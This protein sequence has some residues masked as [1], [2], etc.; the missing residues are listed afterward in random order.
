MSNQLPANSDHAPQP[1]LPADLAQHA[2]LWETPE[3]GSPMGSAEQLKRLLGAVLRRKWLILG[4]TAV[5]AGAGVVVGR[6]VE[7]EYQAQTT[8][9]IESPNSSKEGPIQTGLLLS[10]SAW[11]DLLRSFVVLDYVVAREKLFIESANPRDFRSFALQQQFRPGRYRVEVSGDGRSF[12]LSLE[13]AQIQRGQVGEPVGTEVGFDWK[14]GRGILSPGRTLD[15]EVRNPRD[16]A[17][18]LAGT[19]RPVLNKENNFLR[20][21]LTGSDPARTARTLNTLADRYVEVAAE[22]K[23]DKLDQ[24]TAVL[25]EQRRYA[26]ENLR[27][28]E[29]GLESFRVQTITLPSDKGTPMAAGLQVTTDPVLSR[30]F[31]LQVQRE[32]LRSDRESIDRILAEASQSALSMDALLTVSSV[33]EAPALRTVLENRIGKRA[34]LRTTLQRY[35]PEHPEAVKIREDMRELE[36][37]TIPELTGELEAQLLDREAELEARIASA[38]G[39]LRQIPPRAIEEARLQR[40]VSTAENLHKMLKQ[41]FEEARLAAAS[42]IPDIRVLDAATVPSRPVSDPRQV[43]VLLGLLGGL[44]ISVLGTVVIDRLDSHVRYPEEITH[45]MG[46]QILG[47]VP[48]VNLIGGGGDPT[49]VAAEAFREL[50]LSLI[51]A[52]GSSGPVVTTISSPGSGDGKSFVAS[53]LAL[54]FADQGFRTL[55]IDGDIRRGGLHRTLD[56]QRTLG[57]TDF[58][59]GGAA[60]EEVIQATKFPNVHFIGAGTRMVHGPELLGSPAMAQLLVNVRKRF[61]AIIVDS[62]PLGAGVDAYALGTITHNLILVVRTGATDRGF[63]AA[64]LHVLDRLPIRVLGA[65]LNGAPLNDSAYKYYSYIPGYSVAG[66]ESTVKALPVG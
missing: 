27:D 41:R 47:V 35:T 12:V 50:R 45:G 32:Q 26:E 42:T 9:W 43:F 37:T 7:P 16:V 40:Q 4:I 22:L 6:M 24:L 20:L 44:G 8:I 58:L 28:A 3:A 46:L 30:F 11:I 64:K 29:I 25:E 39:E 53:N 59:S 17:L 23:R 60:P 54:A 10:S 2:A 14:P 19:L 56:A 5:G 1:P 31:E 62:A 18:Q 38:S 48:Y 55:I 15:F 21:N 66:D 49:A 52:H 34:E 36:Q 61:D 57:L 33:Q 65:V 13:G 63:A 51:H